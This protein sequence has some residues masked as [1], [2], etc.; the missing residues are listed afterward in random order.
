MLLSV[1]DLA[2]SFF[3][4]EGVLKAVDGVSFEVDEGET[5][6]LVG[7]SG[8]GKTIVALA[9]LNLVP[10]PGRV[11]R[12]AVL[13]DGV[14]LLRLDAEPLRRARGSGIGLVFQEPGAALNPVYTVGSQIA[15]VVMLHRGL[16]RHAA[17][18]EAVRL[19][20]EMGIPEP[21]RRAR[22]Y[23]HELSGGMRQRATIAI[24]I[25]A[26]PKLLI[27][28][29]P[30]TALDVT[31]QAEIL[32]LLKRVQELHRMAL[33]LIT[34]DIGVVEAL[35]RRVMV[36]Y[37]GKLVEVAPATALFRDPQ[38]PYTRG[39]LGS[40]LRLGAGRG[41]PL[42]GIPGTVPD[43]LALPAG[44]T[45]HPRCPLADTGCTRAFPPLEPL[46]GGRQCACYKVHD[47]A[48]G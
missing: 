23:P 25:S 6:A 29:E 22:A 40:A 26:R 8:C 9:L 14:D 33:L 15:E 30:T 12:G 32:D 28:D 16:T 27:A 46:P 17:E 19:L 7:E 43:L 21:E 1:R 18:G 5:V 24:A 44:C 37:T 34:H 35:A 41:A 45:F 38:H 36:M 3:L 47:V 13:F 39:L 11:V 42:R 4:D 48:V 20:G 2:A 10:V 31:I